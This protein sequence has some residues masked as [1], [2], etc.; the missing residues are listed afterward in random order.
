[1]KERMI[2]RL[3]CSNCGNQLDVNANFCDRC[4]QKVKKADGLHDQNDR[5]NIY[6]DKKANERPWPASTDHLANEQSHF[7]STEN[8][9]Q[10]PNDLETMGSSEFDEQGNS[11]N[12]EPVE[13]SLEEDMLVYVG[14]N[15]HF[16]EQK[17]KVS[18]VKGTSW[19]WSSF[20]LGIGW[21]GYRKMYKPV[22]IIALIFLLVDVLLYFFESMIFGSS[23]FLFTL[24]NGLGIGLGVVLGLY[25]NTLYQKHVRKNTIQIRSSYDDTQKRNFMLR[26]KGG[27]SVGGVFAAIAIM[28]GVYVIPSLMIPFQSY[29]IEGVKGGTFYEY[30][31]VTIEDL[32]DEVFDHTSW[33]FIGTDSDYDFVEFSGTMQ[34]YG[35]DF[36]V[37]IQFMIDGDEFEVWSIYIDGEALAEYEIY[38][39]L[40]Y[41]FIEYD[42][43]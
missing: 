1:M 36:D 26:H 10:Q 16:Y 19:N 14:K 32:F 33:E 3:Y 30:P 8:T 42:S 38:E 7:P 35:Y 17:W 29:A 11:P 9:F 12:D 31:D 13:N 4:G 15:N 24:S 22:L 20:F 5:G 21:L 6:E 41:I 23:S 43:Y 27:T 40:D 18:E 2:R 39:F 34:S 37:T 25:G 28:L